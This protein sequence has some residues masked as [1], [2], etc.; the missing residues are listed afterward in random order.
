MLKHNF[1]FFNLL[2]YKLHLYSKC[3]AFQSLFSMIVS[4]KRCKFSEN[5]YVHTCIQSAY[6]GS[7]IC[8][9]T[10]GNKTQELTNHFHSLSK[11]SPSSLPTKRRHFLNILSL[12]NGGEGHLTPKR[13]NTPET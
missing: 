2:F 13:K 11:A 6:L 9:S 3:M 7:I 5:N 10:F 12:N 4:L 8:W 1:E